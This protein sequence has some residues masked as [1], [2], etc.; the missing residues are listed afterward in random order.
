MR[1]IENEI[2]IGKK[3]IC[4]KYKKIEGKKV[5]LENNITV[6]RKSHKRQCTNF[7]KL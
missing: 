6:H 1:K 3:I 4:R 7:L 5:F 2:N